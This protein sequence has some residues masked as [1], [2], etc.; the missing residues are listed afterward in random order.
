[1]KHTVQLMFVTVF[2]AV[3]LTNLYAA[4][5]VSPTSAPP[6]EKPG[7]KLTFHDEF[8]AP[9]L[10]DLYWYPAYRTGRIEYLKRIGADGIYQDPNAYYK[11]EDGILKLIIDEKIPSRQK[12]ESNAVSCIATSDHRFGKTTQEYQLLEKFAQKYGWFEIRC[13]TVH[14]S[15][16]YTAF[17]LHQTDPTDQEFT[18]QG[19][20][21]KPGDGVVEIDIFEQW[22]WGYT[23]TIELNV[24]F[25]TNGRSVCKLDFDPAK[26]FHVYAMEWKEGE[27]N[28]YVDGK[29]V[30][31][32]KGETPQKKMFILAALFH[33][34]DWSG[35]PVTELTYPKTFEIDYIRAYLPEEK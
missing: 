34:P 22:G 18:P 6:L 31:T 13:K 23:N 11:L 8:D 35:K 33:R 28:W 17:W 4:D 26:D 29:K 2:C 14:G 30:F 16:V 1:M 9:L 12:K 27:L 32:Y 20:R 24:H 7:W 25:T 19:Q 15:G 3:V 10:N 21:K 5:P